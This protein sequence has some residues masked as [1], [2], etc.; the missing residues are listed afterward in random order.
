MHLPSL[1]ADSLPVNYPDF[2]QS[3]LM[4]LIE[5]LLEEVRYSPGSK[6]MQVQTVLNGKNNRFWEKAI[7]VILH[8]ECLPVF[9]REAVCPPD[10]VALLLWTGRGT[11]DYRPT[12]K[13]P[14]SLEGRDMLLRTRGAQRDSEHAGYDWYECIDIAIQAIVER[15]HLVIPLHLY[16]EAR[17][18]SQ[19]I[20]CLDYV[21]EVV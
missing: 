21:G 2:P 17:L 18:I 9:T 1:R 16:G 7:V 10:R 19:L 6:G 4:T 13:A 8:R 11:K 5:I 14:F 12:V 15:F 3:C 20:H